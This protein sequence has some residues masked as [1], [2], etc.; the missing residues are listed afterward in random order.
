[1]SMITSTG[2]PKIRNVVNLR[3]KAKARNEQDV[4]LVEGVRLWREV[5]P[6]MRLETYVSESFLKKKEAKA[7]LKDTAYEAVSDAVLESMSDT[8]TPQGILGVVRQFHYRPDALLGQDAAGRNGGAEP[9]FVLILENLQDPGNL[10]TI[11]R[12]AEGA[13]ATGVLLSRG[14][15][16]IYNPKVIRSTMGSVMRVPF[17]YAQDLHEVLRDWKKK[18]LRL[19][20]AHLNGKKN[21]SE[22]D[23]TGGCGFLIG[24][25]GQGLTDETA[26]LAD[27]YVRIPMKG[28]VESLNASVAASLLA[29]EVLRQRG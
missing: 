17:C 23:Y 1:M 3:K 12:S 25:E 11:L 24:N 27:V 26:S 20:A 13:G 6:S 16:D 5:P 18:G 4:F 21:F 7:L 9:P 29:Y 8:R 28:R 19:Y 22:E 15:V 2:N 10:G 14:C